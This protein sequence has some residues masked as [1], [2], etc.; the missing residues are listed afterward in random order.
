M[1]YQLIIILLLINFACI[2]SK[3]QSPGSLQKHVADTTVIA[4]KQYEKSA[5]HRF[6]WGSNYR[7]VWTAPVKVPIFMLDTAVGGLKPV[8]EG[9]GHQTQSLRLKNQNDKEY[10]LRSVSKTLGAVLPEAFKGTFLEKQVNDEV[11]MSNPYGAAI[12]PVLADAAKV[13]HTNPV[14]VYL[15]AQPALDTFNK[16][17]GGNLYL[18]EQKT[19]G[20]WSAADNLGNFPEFFNT[21]DVIKKMLEDNRYK[22][23]QRSFIRA[24][25]FDWFI[26]DWDRHEDQWAWG[27]RKKIMKLYLFRCHK[28][29]T[30]L[31]LNTMAYC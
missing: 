12:V 5:W 17:Y 29:A 19:D 21:D 30:R 15:P 20:N 28:I 14:Y 23:D 9:G 10:A 25:I 26:N 16:K 7:K 18:F 31:F 27:E 11:T 3:A 6:L 22:V 4:G 1:K 13:Y 2:N 24:R 8:K